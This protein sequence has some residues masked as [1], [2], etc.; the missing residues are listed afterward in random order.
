MT[1]HV[2]MHIPWYFDIHAFDLTYFNSIKLLRKIHILTCNIYLVS[3]YKSIPFICLTVPGG[4][5]GAMD[6]IPWRN[7][8]LKGYVYVKIDLSH[9]ILIQM[10]FN[11]AGLLLV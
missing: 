7:C 9:G 8:A 6:L 2:G 10:P 5:I 3:F 1:G 11:V 4:R